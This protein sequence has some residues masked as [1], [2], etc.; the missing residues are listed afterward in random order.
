MRTPSLRSFCVTVLLDIYASAGGVTVS[1]FEWVQNIQRFS[2]NEERV[3]VELRRHL[4]AAY[5]DLTATAKQ[6]ACDLRA[7]AFSLAVS[8]VARATELRGL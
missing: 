3:R 4:H 5:A 2:W 8:R 7:A 1:Y 6:Q